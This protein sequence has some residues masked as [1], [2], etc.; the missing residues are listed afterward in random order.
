MLNN[1]RRIILGMI[2]NV[3]TFVQLGQVFLRI[4]QLG[5]A[6][7]SAP[8][9]LTI[10]LIFKINNALKIVPQVHLLILIQDVALMPLN[11]REIMWQ[12]L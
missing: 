9:S 3:L 2:K 5:F 6:L 10:I 4:I 12:I 11:A 8:S 7:T 1:V